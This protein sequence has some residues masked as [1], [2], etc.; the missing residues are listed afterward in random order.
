[1]ASVPPSTSSLI[2]SDEVGYGAWAGPLVVCACAAPRIW[3]LPPGLNDS[4]KLSPTVRVRVY[5]ELLSVKELDF[6]LM[7]VDSKTID[8]VGVYKAVKMAHVRAIEQLY[9]KYPGSEVI[10][11]GTVDTGAAQPQAVHL[12]IKAS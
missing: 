3:T 5:N 6:S 10:V 9:A 2:A 1:M 8:E 4:K 11:D 12:D 7:G